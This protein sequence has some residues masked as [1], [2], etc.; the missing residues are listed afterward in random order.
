M[1]MLIIFVI[2]ASIAIITACIY[3]F[4]LRK[5]EKHVLYGIISAI[6]I[7]ASI[8]VIVYCYG[9]S[10]YLS[11]EADNQVIIETEKSE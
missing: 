9:T 3:A 7:L 11:H 6:L 4:I 5:S 8:G 2:C 10:A 1:G